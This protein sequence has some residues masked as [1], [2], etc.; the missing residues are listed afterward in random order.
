MLTICTAKSV[1]L[2]CEVSR[3][4]EILHNSACRLIT[5]C[6][7]STPTPLLTVEAGIPPITATLTAQSLTCF[8]KALRVGASFPLS[9]LARVSIKQRLKRSSWRTFCS[10]HPLVP[11]ID[12]PREDLV[13]LSPFPPWLF[14]NFSL[15]LH[16][17]TPCRRTDP[18]THKSAAA[19][20][21][22]ASLGP[23]DLTVWTDGS[24]P[25]PSGPGGAGIF[26][27]CSLCSSSISLSYP[28][29]PC[30]SSFTAEATGV[31]QALL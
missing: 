23:F 25:E 31:Q 26:A 8:E 27:I 4:L 13:S 29:G 28:S 6:L 3:S 12:A 20:D 7:T 30:C 9:H 22:F 14:P 19:L 17:D 21:T 1:S 24:V 18:P 16:L 2:H 15:H 10:H 11:A 5:G